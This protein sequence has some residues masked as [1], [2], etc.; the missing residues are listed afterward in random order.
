M[1]T[2]SLPTHAPSVPAGCC[3]GGHYVRIV[4]NDADVL[5]A[6]HQLPPNLTPDGF[7]SA[8]DMDWRRV[9]E[10]LHERPLDVIYAYLYDGDSGACRDVTL[11]VHS[12]VRALKKG[13]VPTVKVW[14][15]QRETA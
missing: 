14:D 2:R 3:P 15:L 1:P 8:S 5:L 10:W 12:D 6:E 4:S 11:V 7:D 9:E 13:L